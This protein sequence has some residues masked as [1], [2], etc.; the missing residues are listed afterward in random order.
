[1][2]RILE[3]NKDSTI[4]LVSK[5]PASQIKASLD[6]RAVR[7]ELSLPTIKIG[8]VGDSQS[9]KTHLIGSFHEL[10]ELVNESIDFVATPVDDKSDLI[11]KI[12]R[13]LCSQSQI[14]TTTTRESIDINLC[15]GIHRFPIVGASFEDIPGQYFF[16]NDA[17]LANEFISSEVRKSENSI[18]GSDI[19]FVCLP[20]MKKPTEEDERR[21]NTAVLK[22]LTVVQKAWLASDKEKVLCVLFTQVDSFCKRPKDVERFLESRFC[23]KVISQV[24]G[25]LGSTDNIIYN[26]FPVSAFGLGR[27]QES[28]QDQSYILDPKS[29][30]ID[31][32]GTS[33]AF[34]WSI[35]QILLIEG[36]N[37]RH[38]FDRLV[39]ALDS[40]LS[41]LEARQ[42]A[43]TLLKQ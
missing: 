34:L 6:K 37:A 16:A 17:D 31:P 5:H 39:M 14:T 40:S 25:L 30:N 18:K 33:Y 29:G 42:K 24:A 11:G 3:V 2:A 32:F 12:N 15:Q 23:K 4:E 20:A 43:V 22:L 13:E 41:H 9:G 28:A 38:D 8:I 10:R 7:I 27:S 36:E 35:A 1:M 19:I 26:F 21:A